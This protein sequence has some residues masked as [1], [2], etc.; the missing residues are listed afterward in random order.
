MHHPL[1]AVEGLA[2][3]S[4]ELGILGRAEGY[5][6]DLLARCTMRI[7]WGRRSVS[8]SGPSRECI[9]LSTTLGVINLKY[10][11]SRVHSDRW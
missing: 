3:R 11:L 2:I 6:P 10:Q 5:V 9:L 8:S 1:G 7:G 4:P